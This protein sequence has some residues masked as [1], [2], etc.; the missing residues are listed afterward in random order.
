MT[1]DTDRQQ[2]VSTEQAPPEPST[3][4]GAYLHGHHESVLRSHTWRTVANSAAYLVPELGAGQRVLDVGCGP[5]TITVDLARRVAPGEVIGI[6]ASA[7]IVRQAEGLAFDEGV[8]NVRFRVGDVYAIDLPDASVDVVHAHQFMQHLSDPVSA[9]REIRRVL[10]P[11]GVFAARDVD[12]GGVMVYPALPGL[13]AWQRVYRQVHR[14]NGGEPDAGR[15]LTAWARAA[16]FTDVRSS[17]SIWC[18]ATDVEREWW[19]QSWAVRAL[20]SRFA[21]HA[22]EADAATLADLHEM[23]HAWREWAGH[24]DGWFGMPHGEIL[25]RL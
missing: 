13:T 15:H 14:W 12:Y 8:H 20:E 23:A 5:G 2:P 25:A 3:A 18:F 24:P 1:D 4:R 16:G 19:G 11:G 10:R 6:D 7:D 21:A 9:M 22:I 17:A